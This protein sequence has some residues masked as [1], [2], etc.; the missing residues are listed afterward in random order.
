MRSTWMS[1]VAV[2]ALFLGAVLWPGSPSNGPVAESLPLAA[3][4]VG[5]HS[6]E[7][8]VENGDPPAGWA[9]RPGRIRVLAPQ[10]E[11]A[12]P[13]EDPSPSELPRPPELAIPPIVPA[14]RN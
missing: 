2:A 9:G 3:S 5:S 1:F 4:T 14:L 8:A 7:R 12:D 10:V 11:L 6:A 13:G